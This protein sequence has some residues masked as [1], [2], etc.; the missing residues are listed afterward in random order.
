MQ[1]KKYFSYRLVLI[2]NILIRWRKDTV[3]GE[4]TEVEGYEIA[5]WENMP[6]YV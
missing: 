1:Y 2:A 4:D 3:T 5:I 6:C